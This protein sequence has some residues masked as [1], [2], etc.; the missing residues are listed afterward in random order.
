MENHANIFY[1]KKVQKVMNRSQE[2]GLV[3]KNNYSH[4]HNFSHYF[5]T[6]TLSADHHPAATKLVMPTIIHV[7]DTHRH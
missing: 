3:L 6:Q 7:E 4:S 2:N 1:A 5:E